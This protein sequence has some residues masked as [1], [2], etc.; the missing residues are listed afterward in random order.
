MAVGE[1]ML[2]MHRVF[3]FDSTLFWIPQCQF[4]VERFCVQQILVESH[5]ARSTARKK[6]HRCHFVQLLL[7]DLWWSCSEGW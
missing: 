6:K 1:E 2:E 4:F 5:T 3:I 7:T